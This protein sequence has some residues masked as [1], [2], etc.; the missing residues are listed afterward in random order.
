MIFLS[1]L[2][3]KLLVKLLRRENVK[4]IAFGVLWF[5]V[6][7]VGISMVGGMLVGGIAG[8]Q[9]P[10]NAAQAGQL[11]GEKF[12]ATYGP[13]IMLAAL[14]ISISGTIAGFLPGTKKSSNDINQT[15]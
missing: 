6:L 14:V 8:A 4:K 12:G 11:A 9:D 2:V 1:F 5:I 3:I 13:F 10:S 7:L 15:A